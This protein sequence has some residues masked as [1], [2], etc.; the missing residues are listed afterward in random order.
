MKNTRKILTLL[1][2][3]AL[4]VA[5][6]SISAFADSSAVAQTDTLGYSEVL[7]K[8]NAVLEFYE[9]GT[10]FAMRVDESG[11]VVID[12][13]EGE[14]REGAAFSA[15]VTDGV[16]SFTSMNE[17]K[18]V[19]EPYV[20]SSF[21][22]NVRAK[23]TEESPLTL[24]AMSSIT[25]DYLS[26][27]SVSVG[28][29]SHKLNTETFAYDTV[30]FALA[31]NEFFELNVFVEKS[32]GVDT[33]YYT[34]TTDAGATLSGKYS[35]DNTITDF[36]NGKFDFDGAYLG[37]TAA[38]L[39]YVEM[40]PGTFQRY[41][42]NSKNVDVIA[43]MLVTTYN[44]YLAYKNEGAFELAEIIAKIAVTYEYPVASVANA[45]VKSVLNTAFAECI[46][47]T[48]KVYES[49]MVRC[50]NEILSSDNASKAYTDRREVLETLYSYQGY[51]IVLEASEF[52][53]VSGVDFDVVDAA[54]EVAYDEEDALDKIEED[55]IFVIDALTP[56]Y[57]IYLATYEELKV[58]YE[59]VLNVEICATYF[60]DW[61]SA[62]E[63]AD[64]VYKKKVVLTN[65]PILN[66]KAKAFVAG[67]V[68]ATDMSS[69]FSSRYSA[70][71]TAKNNRFADDTY[72]KYLT[73]TTIA[74][75]NA[76]FDVVDVEMRAVTEVAEAFLA[77][78]R[79]A[80]MTPSYTVKIEALDA[81]APYI[82]VVETGYPEVE[83][84]IKSYYAL[85]A[86]VDA[87]QEAARRY[88]QAVLNVQ[89]AKGVKAKLAA[90]AIA[91]SFAV[92]GSEASVVV[93]GMPITVT[94]ANIILSNEKSAIT[95]KATRINNYVSATDA[96]SNVTELLARRQAINYALSLKA[97]LTED[98]AEEED[99]VNATAALNAA[100]A[101]YNA[102]VNTANTAAEQT[103]TVAL[104]I[105]AK[106]VPTKR[107]AEVIAIVKKFY[108]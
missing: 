70:Y 34:I 86:D 88:V 4:L 55:T 94:E 45:D 16:M 85:R 60:S 107:I 73:D 77:K 78:I 30:D 76:A 20:P 82:D 43:D 25:G 23:I 32:T 96:I 92:L 89:I 84:A 44:D 59:T 63:V 11:D 83:A 41:V 91:E 37:S 17:T 46:N 35:Y 19:V 74:E 14:L 54:L 52:A 101:A 98:D 87:R 69:D 27:L 105:A 8:D 93:D 62:E 58:A 79:E 95:L 42:D 1:L 15:S 47:V 3:L 56:I 40:Y 5:G 51:M 6:F 48:S 106:T 67:V 66:E 39:E 49:D 10:Y 97:G 68:A 24:Y 22:V 13:Y 57:N 72:D 81:A 18:M 65:Y 31:E 50:Q 102:E 80:E 36:V 12:G 21:G 108:E 2:S 75:L 103:E 7:E 26:L 28:K 64:A 104:T 71:I 38:S 90:I 61:Y 9:A 33:V 29:I 100:I 99:V 53:T